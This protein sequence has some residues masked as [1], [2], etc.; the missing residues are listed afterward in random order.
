MEFWKLLEETI[1]VIDQINNWVEPSSCKCSYLPL[2]LS[3]LATM[4]WELWEKYRDIWTNMYTVSEF[5]IYILENK[6]NK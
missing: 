1:S 6:K 2:R 4:N 5:V 3:V